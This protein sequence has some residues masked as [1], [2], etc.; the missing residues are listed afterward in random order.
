MLYAIHCLDRDNALRNRLDY[1]DA[2][3]NYLDSAII[4]IVLAGP[5]TGDDGE[6]P[7]GSFFVV[8]AETRNEVIRF[9]QSDPFYRLDVWAKETIRIHPFL[10]RRGWKASD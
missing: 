10:K 3:R 8:S 9:N 4:S 1:Y 2:H 6:T 5:I 7:V